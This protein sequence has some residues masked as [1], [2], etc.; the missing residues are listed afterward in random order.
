[1]RW[2]VIQF[3]G[4]NCDQDVLHVLQNVLM[5]EAAYVWHKATSLNGADAVVLPGGF[6]YGDYLRCGAIARFSPIMPAVKKAAAQGKTVLGI[7]NGFQIL[8]EA[9]LLPGI[10]I[11]NA[12]LHFRCEAIPVRVEHPASRFTRDY[13][14]GQVLRLPIAHGEGHYVA[15]EA[16]LD[17]LFQ[18]KQVLFTYCDAQG[19]NTPAANPNGSQRHIAGITNRAGNVLGLMPH[20]ERASEKILGSDDGLGLFTSIFASQGEALARAG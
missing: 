17:S 19:R 1:M 11:R 9:G 13:L 12:S 4:S 5:Q 3:P 15:D 14:A 8:C 18:H 20:P 6:S 2:A 16:T 7:C 10:L